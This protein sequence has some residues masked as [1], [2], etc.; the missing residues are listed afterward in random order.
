M[1]GGMTI[2]NSEGDDGVGD[3]NDRSQ[4]QGSSE[5]G[6]SGEVHCDVMCFGLVYLSECGGCGGW[7]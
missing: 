7:M 6:K 4:G 1:S 5:E 3:S 2:S